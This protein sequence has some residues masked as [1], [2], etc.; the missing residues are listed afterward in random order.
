ME[1]KQ[2]SVSLQREGRVGLVVI[3]K[4]PLNL[5]DVEM[6]EGLAGVLAK[7]LSDASL[8]AVLLCSE[9]AHFM[10]G[11]DISEFDGARGGPSL[12]DIQA[13]VESA[14]KPIVAAIQGMALGGGLELA[15]A[16]HYRVADGAAK[17]GL[18]EITLGVI[19]GA[20]GT[21]RLPRLVGARK[22][23]GII[24]A[25]TP[26][27]AAEAK[28]CG[29]IDAEAAGEV[30]A[31][32]LA[33]CRALIEKGAAIRR[34]CDLVADRAGFDA[35]GIKQELQAHA[36]ALKGR[37]TQMLVVSAVTAAVERPF[38]A[39]LQIEAQLARQSLE[40]LESRALRHLFFAERSAGK[41]KSDASTAD[42]RSYARAAVVGAGT[43]G[44]GIATALADA[45]LALWLI[46]NTPGGLARGQSFIRQNYLIGNRMM[47]DGYFREAEQLLLEGAS[48]AQLDA[49]LESFGF[50][51]GPQKV[52]DLGGT[53][54]GTK[55][56]QELYRAEHRPAPYFVIADRLTA[57]GRLGQKTGSGFYSYPEG[58][59]VAVSDAAVARIIESLAAA[60][61]IVRRDISDLEIVERCLLSL[62]N[63]GAAVLDEGVA[64][65]SADID[66]VW[67]S[68]YGFPRHFGG[69]MFYADSLGL[70]HVAERI[71]HY[72][73]L[74][75]HYWKPA[76]L[77]QRLADAKS[78]FRQWDSE[79]ATR[80]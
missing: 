68:G 10:A 50:A 32:A 11:V 78:S 49:A 46:D 44:S 63:V 14:P 71:R 36:R 24:L 77:I 21:Q 42:E 66:V 47:L 64:Q 57:L 30:R 16:C 19:P 51:M 59:R 53:D 20:G 75:G 48:P 62:I 23:L 25:G 73:Y 9:G 17:L 38:G 43:M 69:P 58:S 26:L 61:H 52:S 65:S 40:S 8:D 29:L 55:A 28:A 80:R 31:E 5:I 3:A 54:V 18:P 15:M 7:A 35:E 79:R 41:V 70:P 6:R 2:S 27:S 33:Y 39:G 22:A 76:A 72:H 4:P 60:L 45:G 67:T 37:T 1:L 56:R 34:T 12:Q 13:T 74:L